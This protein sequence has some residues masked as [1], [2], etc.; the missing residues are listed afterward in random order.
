MSTAS[1]IQFQIFEELGM[2]HE[3]EVIHTIEDFPYSPDADE[4]HK[5]EHGHLRYVECK[6]GC[7]VALGH[8]WYMRVRGMAQALEIARE[9]EE[10]S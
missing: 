9:E 1:K 7:G 2:C 4:W 8:G 6:H 10:G 3:R 5:D